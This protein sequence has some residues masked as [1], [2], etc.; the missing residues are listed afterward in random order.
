[1]II[2]QAKCQREPRLGNGLAPVKFIDENDVIHFCNLL[3]RQ[4][5]YA[6]VA[7]SQGMVVIDQRSDEHCVP[8]I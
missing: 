3:L 2:A 7:Y 1:M 8:S 5:I 6:L 4:L